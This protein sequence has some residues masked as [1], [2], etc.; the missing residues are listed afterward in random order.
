MIVRMRLALLACVAALASP[1]P[2]LAAEGLECMAQSYDADELAILKGFSP[3]F[4]FAEDPGSPESDRVGAVV[5]DAVVGC[6]T[7]NDWSEDAGFY[8][9][10]FEGGRVIE[11][12]FR[13]SPILTPS[14]LK[15]LDSALAESERPEL[16]AVLEGIVTAEMDGRGSETTP[17]EN[18]ALGTFVISIGLG[19]DEATH[20]KVGALLGLLAMQR[21]ATREFEATMAEQ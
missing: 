19:Q 7:K 13:R 2:A 8:A 11:A 14:E 12:A 6:Q 3:E 5:T 1:S 18:Y 9:T 20:E 10:M 21:V 4:L 17:R 15:T 16:W